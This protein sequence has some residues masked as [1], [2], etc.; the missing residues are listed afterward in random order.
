[1]NGGNVATV[2]RNV[3]TA[4]KLVF[5]PNT[6]IPIDQ[7]IEPLVIAD[8]DGDGKP[9]FVATNQGAQIITTWLNEPL[10]APPVQPPAPV[11]TALSPAAAPY[12]TTVQITGENFSPGASSGKVVFGATDGQIVSA[13]ATNLTVRVPAGTTYSQVSALNLSTGLAGASAQA[14]DPTLKTPQKLSAASYSTKNFLTIEQSFATVVADINGDGIPD[15]VS[16]VGSGGTTGF[17]VSAGV[18]STKS[19]SY[20]SGTGFGNSGNY[21]TGIAVADIDGDGKPDVILFAADQGVTIYLNAST[22]TN[23]NFAAGININA[24]ASAIAIA[25]V[26]GDGKPDIAVSTTNG[27]ILLL[28]ASTPGTV[29]FSEQTF[30]ETGTTPTAV[31]L[32]DMDG[33]GKADLITSAA[34]GDSTYAFIYLNQSVVGGFAF[35]EVYFENL[36]AGS[37]NLGG[38]ADMDGDGK[39]DILSTAG[40]SLTID[41]NTAIPGSLS[42]SPGMAFPISAGAGIMT[43]NIAIGDIDGDGKPDVVADIIGSTAPILSQEVI[44]LN[45]STSGNINMKAPLALTADPNPLHVTVADLDGDGKPE[46][47]FDRVDD[48]NGNLGGLEFFTNSNLDIFASLSTDYDDPTT[49][50]AQIIDTAVTVKAYLPF[51]LEQ[52]TISIIQNFTAAEDSLIFVG[53]P[54]TTGDI[55]GSYNSTTGV[56]TLTSSTATITQLQNALQSVSYINSNAIRPDTNERVVSFVYTNGTDT[57]NTALK[58]IRVGPGTLTGFPIPVITPNGPTAFLQGD[59]VLL[60][61]TPSTGY[62]YQWAR[63]AINITGATSSIYTAKTSGSYTLSISLNSKTAT[64]DSITVVA[65]F[66]LPADNFKLSITSATC[67]GSIDGSVGIIAQQMEDYTA[68]I[69]G[70]GLNTAYPFTTSTNINNLA[71]GTY[72]VCMTVAGQSAY[73]QCFSVVIAQPAPLSVYSTV[74]AGNKSVSLAL[75]GADAYNISLNGTIYNT[76][77]STITLPLTDGNNDLIV[78]TDRLCQGSVEKLI[79]ISGDISPYP[80]PFQNTLNINLGLNNINNVSVQIHSLPGGGLVFSKQYVNQSGVLQLDLTSLSIGIYSLYLSMDQSEKIFKI[81]KQ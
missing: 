81:T 70:N 53:T 25:D 69:T 13:S 18:N 80:V 79:N 3:S 2:L 10:P 60:S 1:M 22:T 32:R 45:A 23:I 72:S 74:D 9:D 8:M 50:K 12:N 17:A 63:N 67:D 37:L 6:D 27:V 59:S 54:A 24:G 52:A 29:S 76:T 75:S 19:F 42:F 35:S 41:R 62:T 44:L 64:S 47:L 55:A 20:A 31:Q 65:A 16:L 71:A 33:D 57:S 4:D 15:L 39:P 11:I 68:T 40:G 73:Q 61:A 26:D 21:R 66:L 36:G 58:Y 78:S 49:G 34:G 46:I 30:V 14:F 77:D 48:I 56:L 7:Y 28:N 5:S 38:I 43:Q 51:T